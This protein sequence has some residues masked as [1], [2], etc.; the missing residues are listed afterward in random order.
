MTPSRRKRIYQGMRHEASWF[1]LKTDSERE[2]SPGEH[3]AK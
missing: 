2:G 1:V 3:Y